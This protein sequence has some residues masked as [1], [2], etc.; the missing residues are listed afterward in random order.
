[1][2]ELAFVTVKDLKEKISSKEISPQEVLDFFLKRAHEYDDRFDSLLEVFD[3]KSILDRFHEVEPLFGIPGVIKDNICQKGRTVSCA[4]KILENFKATYDA[5]V[6][7]R[8]KDTGAT[9]LGRANCDEFSMGSS[10]E[11]SAYKKTKNPWDIT[12]VPGGSSGGPAVAVAAGLVP[13]ALGSDTGGS[14]RQPA[15]YC[16]IVGLKPTYGLVSRFGLVAY[17]SSLDQI[18][19]FSRSVFDNAL[20][21][22]QIAGNDPKDSSSLAIKQKDY[23]LG[24]DGKLKDRLTI[25]VVENALSTPGMC[26]EVTQAI[27]DAVNVFE[28]LGARIKSV[29]LTILDYTAA[30]YF[31]ISRAE[32]ASNL[33][34]FDGVRYGIRK[35]VDTLYNMYLNTRHDGFGNEVKNRIMIGNYVLSV[36]HAGKFYDNAKRVQGLLQNEFKSA[37]N[38]VD[39]LIFPTHSAPAFRIGALDDNPLQMALEDYFTSPMNLAGIPA[40]SIPCGFSKKEK[41]PIGFQLAG[42]HLSEELIYKIAYAY[43]QNTHW[44]TIHPEGC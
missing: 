14:V 26:P 9:F 24:L 25:G 39:L 8:L 15:A 19:V 27:R 40:I 1:M 17:A 44:H 28:K 21:F 10:T 43:E 35:K 38:E 41:L 32:A 22:S 12:R 3:K 6:I 31:I 13:W 30:C 20:I 18:G 23:T 4:S 7:K 33:A 5:T 36:G 2:K 11:N 37:F 34:R 42:P 16:G 29:S